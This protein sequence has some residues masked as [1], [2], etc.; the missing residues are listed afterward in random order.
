MTRCVRCDQDSQQ[1]FL[2][3]ADETVAKSNFT[4]F[5]GL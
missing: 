3:G 5:A 4:P 2:C 1:Y